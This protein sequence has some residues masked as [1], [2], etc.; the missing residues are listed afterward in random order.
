MKHGFLRLSALLFLGHCCAVHAAPSPADGAWLVK[1]GE[2]RG[3]LFLP[4]KMGRPLLFASEELREYVRK[5]TGA[6][7]PIAYRE[8]DVRNKKDT[9]IWLRVRDREAWEGKES[10]QAFTI[11]GTV[12]PSPDVPMTGVAIVGNTEMAVLFGVYQYLGELGVRWFAPGE[13][14]ENVPKLAGIAVTA[15]R[16]SYQPSFLERGLSLSGVHDNHFDRS[17]PV[18]YR[19][20]IHHDYDLWTLRNRTAFQRYIHTGHWFD[21][22]DVPTAGNHGIKRA[23][24]AGADIEVEPERYALVTRDGVA[25]RRNAAAQICFTHEKN[26]RQ[27]IESAVAYFQKRDET[28]RE[29]N[30]DLDDVADTYAMGLAD[31]AGICEC[32]N[33]ARVA[34][35]PPYNKDRLVWQFMNRV[36][37][38]VSERRPGAKIG[39][40]APYF[41]LK[42]PPPDVRIASNIV[43]VGCRGVSWSS[44]PADKPFYPFTREYAENI[45]ATRAA[46]AEM[47]CYDYVMWQGTPQPLSI[48]DAAVAYKQRGT[49]HY[50]AEVMTRNEQIWP[51]LWVLSQI[52]WNSEQDPH[53]L[54]AE[55]CTSYFGPGGA[56]VLDVLQRMDANSRT[57]PRVGYGGFA[58]TQ[59]IMSDALIAH[60]RHA[61]ETAIGASAG[62]ERARLLRFRDTFEMFARTA[63]TYRGYCRAL[64]ERTPEAIAASVKAFA[65]YETFWDTRRLR[66]TCSPGVLSKMQ[67]LAKN[68][69]SPLVVPVGRRELDDR[70]RWLA[71]L[72]AFDHVPAEMPNLFPLP[73]IWKFKVDD[74][75]KGLQEGWQAVDCDDS[76]GWQTISTWNF[77]E[78][79]GYKE[80]NG[81]F[82]YRLKV[83]IPAFPA[84]RR[85]FMRIGSL[86]DDGDI[87]INGQLA[88][89]RKHVYPD[90]WQSSF[91]FDATPFL[92]P[93]EANVVAIRGYDAFG[94]GGLWRPCA[95]YTD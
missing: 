5:M 92:K 8:L 79:Q 82:W 94:A 57:L 41:E 32:E 31:C 75:D 35:A 16:R 53:A 63:E 13:L 50:H 46:G 9:G 69:I 49:R 45:E 58:D 25:A 90:D 3:H 26:V 24:L 23:A 55:Y 66:E 62:R 83:D 6:E 20:G 70:E 72:F 76:L 38:G 15:G 21:F 40:F 22:N 86:D 78:S 68:T 17:D 2:A 10:S 27:A 19:D 89:A 56:Q 43:A 80:I 12:K 88:H 73:E 54:L 47:R 39:L 67:S 51:V 71:D 60:G 18:R 85:V 33:C 61:L 4:S 36:A 44:E 65:D 95:L 87:Y 52:L 48:L 37:E 77:F 81:R 93:G 84:G 91:V 28:A 7:L 1:D 59:A 30:T 64:N 14:G 29:R 11:E 74:E 34:G 42:Q